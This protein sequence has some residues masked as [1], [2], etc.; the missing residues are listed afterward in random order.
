MTRIAR[1]LPLA[2]TATPST[3]VTSLDSLPAASD[4]SE[5]QTTAN[6]IANAKL[7]LP[8]QIRIVFNSA[9]RLRCKKSDSAAGKNLESKRGRKRIPDKTGNVSMIQ[10]F[11]FAFRQLAK[12]PGFTTIAVLTLALGIGINSAIFALINGV[13]LRP[14]VPVRP[15]EVV[16]VFNARQNAKHDYRQF[17]YAEYRE[18][19]DNGEIFADVAAVEFAVAGIGQ[20]HQMRRSLAFL[21]SENFFSLIGVRPVLGRFYNAA[22]CAPNAGQP[23]VVASYGFWKRLG[24]GADLIGSTLHINGQPY[25]L[26]GVTPDGFSGGSALVAPDIWLPLGMH[27]ELGS[28][29]ND[30]E[31]MHDLN[32]PKN[33]AL[34]LKARLRP[35]LSLEA[36]RKR[37]PVFNQRLADIQRSDAEGSRELQIY[38]PSRF[39]I[40]TAPEDDGPITLIATLLTAM[41]GAVLL[42]ACLNLANMLL[43]RGASRSKEIAV[44]LAIG[45]SRWRIVRQLLC[46]GLLLA[47]CGGAIGLVLAAWCNDLLLQQLRSLLASVNFSFVVRLRPDAIVLAVTFLFCLVATMLFS[48]GPA[49]KAT[50]ADL[51]NDLKQQTG[52]PARAGKFGRFFASR[53]ISVMVQIALSLVLLFAAGLFLRG[54]LKAAGLDPGFVA[55]GDLITEFDFSLL[56]KDPAESRRLIFTMIQRA[57]E[58]PGV[59]AAATGTMLPYADFTNTRRVLRTKDTMPDNPQAPDPSV[60]SLYTAI[61]PGY[62]DALGVKLLRG[63]DFTQAECEQ[64]DARRVA[65]IDEEMAKKLFPDQAAVGQHIRYTQPP[66]DGAPNDMEIVGVVGKHRHDIQNDSIIRRLFVPLAQGYSGQTYFHVRLSTQD[67]PAVVAMMPTLR[68][69]LRQIDPDLPLLQMIPYI[70]LV[71]KSPSLWIV[72]LGAILFGA[73]GCIALLLAVVGVYGVKAYAVACRTREIGIRIALGAHR[74]D[75]FALIMRQGALQTGLAITAGLLL[76]LLIGRVLSAILYQVSPADPFALALSSTLLAAAALLACFLPAR[77]ATRVNPVIALR[78]E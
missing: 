17:S 23:V 55:A 21:T 69:T 8:I 28:A 57:R 3:R 13:L 38:P 41:A 50:K 72:R 42:I 31:T 67:R 58:L 48:L 33:Y 24:G 64:K 26:I 19:R 74:R 60:N 76:S 34:N 43:A 27:S 12:S 11:K 56:R 63:R 15:A 7:N 20:D 45:A 51:V 44:R 52:E 29:F 10:D 78:T 5:M 59:T 25:T 2:V 40:S 71:E 70:D 73:F 39:S 35:G 47:L 65:I 77:R 66:K 30:S 9:D 53:H 46:E 32:L 16:D 14:V 4:V 18:L 36:A 22:E 49:L 61:T 54:A 75:V 37:L 1:V 62:F 6:H 68:Q